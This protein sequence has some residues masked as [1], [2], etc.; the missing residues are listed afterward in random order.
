[1]NKLDTISSTYGERFAGIHVHIDDILLTGRSIRSW[2]TWH[3]TCGAAGRWRTAI[4]VVLRA[5]YMWNDWWMHYRRRLIVCA[6]HRS[7]CYAWRMYSLRHRRIVLRNKRW[8]QHIRRRSCGYRSIKA[9]TEGISVDRSRAVSTDAAVRTITRLICV[10]F[11]VRRGAGRR[12]R[13]R[14][15]RQGSA[16]V[17][18]DAA[19]FNRRHQSGR[20]ILG[21]ACD[22]AS[23]RHR[24]S[25]SSRHICIGITVNRCCWQA[26]IGHCHHLPQRPDIQSESDKHR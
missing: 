4:E 11:V 3:H 10:P 9:Q 1:M 19:D 23:L 12:G 8:C 21:W 7:Y 16:A 13:R 18:V 15:R 24:R 20:R 17:T 5:W 22:T 26:V 6:D 2:P 25:G 14:R